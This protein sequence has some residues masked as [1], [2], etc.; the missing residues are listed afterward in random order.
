MQRE[1]HTTACR[2]LA[3][4]FTI[5]CLQGPAVSAANARQSAETGSGLDSLKSAPSHLSA[6][7]IERYRQIF[8]LQERAKWADADRLIAQLSDRVLLSYVLYQRYMH[9]TGYRARFEE[10]S[11][12][13]E[14]YADHPDA[15]RV[16]SLAL[17][18]QPK[19]AASP[20]DP[21]RGYLAGAGQELQERGAMRNPTTI[22]RSPVADALVEDWRNAI[23]ELAADGRLA[24]AERELRRPGIA[25]LVDQ[26]EID[27]A[28]WSIARGYLAA[29]DAR[30]AL[31]LAGRAATRSGRTVPEIHWAAGLSAWRVGQIRVAAWHFSS[32]ANADAELVLPA[33]RARAAFWAARAYLVDRRPQLVSHYLRVAA[34]GRD[35]YGLLARAILAQPLPEAPS[36]SPSGR[37]WSRCCLTT[38]ARAAPSR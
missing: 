10:L 35:F 29:G 9:P 3:V 22:E 30:R 26:V 27:L 8:A 33:E 1:R 18:R 32:L 37:A 13:L 4:F 6:R 12:W 5:A 23:A 11:G 21:V 19:G 14:R 16:Y 17:R 25:P 7:D 31:V 36:R 2:L 15:E 20:H 34:A 24:E 38:P 28:T